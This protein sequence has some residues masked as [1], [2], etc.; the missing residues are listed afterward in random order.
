MRL[1]LSAAKGRRQKPTA[2]RLIV[3]SSARKDGPQD[4]KPENYSDQMKL[5]KHT[6]PFWRFVILSE[7]F[8]RVARIRVNSATEGSNARNE[9]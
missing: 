9:R 7:P 4:D 5:A 8:T 6:G 1:L 2:S 3:C